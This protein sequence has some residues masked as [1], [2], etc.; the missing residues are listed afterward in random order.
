MSKIDVPSETDDDDAKE[1][2]STLSES[3]TTHFSEDGTPE[4]G[5]SIVY[6]NW[7]FISACICTE[8]NAM[9]NIYIFSGDD[10]E[11]FIIPCSQPKSMFFCLDR[12]IYNCCLISESKYK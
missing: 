3:Q 8:S 7:C 11:A 1:Q 5:S 10:D 6:I 4:E 2:T 9:F 12:M